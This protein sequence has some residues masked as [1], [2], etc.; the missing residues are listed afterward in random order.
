M[1]IQ[2]GR[3]EATEIKR[4]QRGGGMIGDNTERKDRG[5]R[6]QEGTEGGGSV[7]IQRGKTEAIEIK[8]AQRGD[9]R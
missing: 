2:R 1:T 9:D 6:D 4:A 5:H 3:T 8:R 7:T